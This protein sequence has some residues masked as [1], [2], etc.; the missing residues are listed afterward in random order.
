MRLTTFLATLVL[1]AST[2]FAGVTIVTNKCDFDVWVTSVSTTTGPTKKIASNSSYTEGQ[3]F[4]GTGTAIKVTRAE[5]G[6]WQGKAVLI[7]AYS[8]TKGG[9]IYY[10]LSSHSG[11]DFW[12]KK[13]TVQGQQGK[14]AEVLTWEGTPKP[15]HTAVYWGETDLTLTLCA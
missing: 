14:G 5:K 12:G 3:Y 2:A 1:T 8:Y 9:P 7:F 15:N 4:D 11:F 13:L 6:L 10:D